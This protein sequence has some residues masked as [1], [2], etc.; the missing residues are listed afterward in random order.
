LPDGEFLGEEG[1]YAAE[2]WW[3]MAVA[4]TVMLVYVGVVVRMCCSLP[5]EVEGP[6][7]HYCQHLYLPKLHRRPSQYMVYHGWSSFLL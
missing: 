2:D 7:G 6:K 1:G 4:S 3:T 5:V